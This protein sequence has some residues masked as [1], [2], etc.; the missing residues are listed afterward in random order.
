MLG[1]MDKLGNY[2]R[3][4]YLSIGVVGKEVIYLVMDNAGGHG[5]NEAVLEY[6]EYLAEIYNILVHHQVLRSSKTNML[7]LGACITIQS[8]GEIFN[9]LNVKQH[10]ALARFVKK[11]C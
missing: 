7:D 6:S 8:K 3:R 9:R 4:T 2:A 11:A 1:I 10:N 5:T